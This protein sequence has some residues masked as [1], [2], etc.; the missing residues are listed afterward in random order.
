MPHFKRPLIVATLF[1]SL[2]FV[3][4]K[5]A[6][7]SVEP[8]KNASNPTQPTPP[9]PPDPPTPPVPPVPPTQKPCDTVTTF[10]EL[11]PL[12]ASKC[13]RCHKGWDAYDNAKT[14]LDAMVAHINI[15]A[16]QPD[17]MPAD[18]GDLLAAEKALF[19]T[20][21]S[22]GFLKAGDCSGTAKPD[23]TN[24]PHFVT[25]AELEQTIS[26][27]LF[28]TN[29]VQVAD[30]VKMRYFVALDLLDQGRVDDVAIA[31]QALNKAL[32]H[33]SVKRDL[34]KVVT[35]APGIWR[36]NIDDL[37]IEGPD[38][39]QIE[40]T[41]KFQFVSKTATGKTLQTATQSD[42][43][44]MFVQDFIDSALE[45][46]STYYR[47]TEVGQTL[48][49]LFQK[50]GVDFS[51]DLKGGLASLLAFNGSV[52]SPSANRLVARFKTDDGVLY[53]TEDTGVILSDAQNVF[54]NPLPVGS[55]GAHT[56]KFA[57]GEVLYTLPNGL[58][59]AYLALADGRRINEADPAV[60]SDY[61][62]NPLRPVI[63]AQV[64]CNR[65]H[66]AGYIPATDQVL[67]TL[68]N[69]KIGASDIQLA[70]SLYDE[71]P[72]WDL[73]FA[74]DSKKFADALKQIDVDPTAPDPIS[75]VEDRNRGDMKLVDV[76]GLFRLTEQQM[77]DCIGISNQG[78][79]LLTGGTISHDQ[80]VQLKDQFIKACLIFQDKN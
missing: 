57:A 44:W 71:Q 26:N 3:V 20:W 24:P 10:D 17:H 28:D 13:V 6:G 70:L 56:L 1:A 61:T 14:R 38:W 15:P 32:N 62:T 21:K 48:P 12:I 2:V 40:L 19:T 34:Q 66:N 47:L 41:S 43:P 16:G 75:R 30:R 53:L 54:D 50:L 39:L 69:S 25:F 11:Q 78:A 73:F 77:R 51:G 79:Q 49:E 29:K 22:D 80:F 37:G 7:C 18:G 23:P 72:V 76:A 74:N 46:G 36:A 68:P 35:I 4:F 63:H 65:C 27:D 60:V 67:N 45:N 42:L 52:L 33:V 9:T 64:S 55:G 31:K 8:K 58:M 5:T 59:G